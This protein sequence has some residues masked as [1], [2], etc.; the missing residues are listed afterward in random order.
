LGSGIKWVIFDENRLPM[1][2]SEE[3]PEAEK[4]RRNL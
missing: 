3:E 1:E 2:L 4:V